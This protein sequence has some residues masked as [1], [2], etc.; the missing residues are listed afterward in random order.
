MSRTVTKALMAPGGVPDDRRQAHGQQGQ[1]GEV[2]AAADDRSQHARAGRGWQWGAGADA[3]MACPMKKVANDEQLR[4]TTRATVAEDEHLAR[5]DQRA[6]GGR[7]SGW[8][9]SCRCRTRRSRRAPRGRPGPAGRRG[10]RSGSGGPGR[11]SAGKPASR[12]CQRT[13]G[14]TVARTPMPTVSTMVAT[15]LQV[16]DRTDAQ[17]RPLRPEHAAPPVVPVREGRRGRSRPATAPRHRGHRAAPAVV[18][19]CPPPRRGGARRGGRRGP[20]GTRRCR[21]SAP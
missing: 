1:D 17:L 19:P 7:R 9:G 18:P 21:R 11:R 15:R 13:A 16:V 8:P 5:E 2:E 10:G 4:S 6:A 20:R 12:L 3:K 14:I